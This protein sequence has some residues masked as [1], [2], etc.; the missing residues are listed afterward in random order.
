MGQVIIRNL[1]DDV[2]RRLKSK[3]ELRG[4]S[5]EQ[6]LREVLTEA[7]PLSGA[8][9]LAIVKRLQAM[10]PGGMSQH[11]STEIIRA[12]RDER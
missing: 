12:A 10:T 1:D 2:I 9:R 4:T 11:D 3:A 5:L 7:A 8:E 6:L